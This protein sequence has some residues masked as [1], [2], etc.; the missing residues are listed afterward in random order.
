MRSASYPASGETR[1][2]TTLSLETPEGTTIDVQPAG[3][4]VRGKAFLFDEFFRWVVIVVG[5]QVGNA[6][7]TAGTGLSLIIMFCTYWLYGVCFDVLNN[8]VSPGKKYQNLRVV[9]DDGTP[10]RLPASMVRNL[11]LS[12][13]ILPLTYFVGITSLLVTQRFQRVGDLAAGTM[14]VHQVDKQDDV[15]PLDSVVKQSPITLLQEEQTLFV[16]YLERAGGL[17]AA[18]ADELAQILTAT[19]AT[20]PQQVRREIEQVAAGYRGVTSDG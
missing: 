16:E 18:R 6:L 12:I 3:L 17:N 1:L 9:H 5:L 8:G 20:T 11:L 10:I 4:F 15:A 2:S 19:L 13:D 7:G 14:V